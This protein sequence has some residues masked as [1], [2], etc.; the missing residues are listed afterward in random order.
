[1]I[2]TE[3]NIKRLYLIIK[4]RISSDKALT[5]LHIGA[6]RTIITTGTDVLVLAIGTEKTGQE[7]FHHAPPTPEEVENAINVVEDEVARAY[8]LT[9]KGSILCT[10]DT[11]IREI[12][13]LASVPD[14][15]EM[16]L[17]REAMESLF[18][19]LAALSMGRPTAKDDL[20]VD[21]SF[22]AT[23]L[24]LREVMFHLGFTFINVMQIAAQ[25]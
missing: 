2:D 11:S 15:T 22:S 13:H 7:F 6:L 3:E 16:L 21:A 24:I 4:S 1:M 17:S 18:T 14:Q 19:R 12:V 8:K 25:N 5:L 9:G 20:R 10:T 23:L